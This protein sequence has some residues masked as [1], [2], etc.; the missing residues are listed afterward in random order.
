MSSTLQYKSI[1][2]RAVESSDI[3]LLY[4]WENDTTIWQHGSTTYPFSRDILQ[5]FIESS[6]FN[7]YTHN[8][9]RFMICHIETKETIGII[10]LY[11]FDPRH[12][13]A[14]IG[15]F[16]AKKHRNNQYANNAIQ[17]CINYCKSILFLQQV[18]AEIPN[19]NLISKQV[20]TKIGFIES[21]IRK[22][23]LKTQDGYIDQTIM[24]CILL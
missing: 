9:L 18:Y 10:D 20:F 4:T 2:L 5:K 6:D 3:D 16:I 15:I 13:R 17:C 24:Q 19:D 14:G 1:F 11:D 21:G 8:Q 12:L 7:I 22:Q 23:W